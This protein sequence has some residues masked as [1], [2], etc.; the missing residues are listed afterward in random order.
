[1]TIVW[2]YYLKLYMLNKSNDERRYL[3]SAIFSTREVM[4]V[5]WSLIRIKHC[6]VV[7]SK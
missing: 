1:M 6:T 2:I 7:F 5:T 4:F 3:C